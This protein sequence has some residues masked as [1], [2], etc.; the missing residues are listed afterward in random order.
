MF[1]KRDSDNKSLCPA[2][3]APC[4]QSKCEFWMYVHGQ[5]PQTSEQVSEGMCAVKAIALGVL[6]GARNALR[7]EAAIE[8]FRN[9]NSEVN[10]MAVSLV[11]T[12]GRVMGQADPQL[13]ST[14]DEP[15]LISGR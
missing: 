9:E 6:E 3:Q 2:F 11:R 4:K 13:P 14:A 7:T 10:H 8:S 5:H 1:G 12:F 15:K